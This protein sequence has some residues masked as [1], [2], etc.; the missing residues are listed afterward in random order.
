[1]CVRAVVGRPVV[2][3]Q[4]V[5]SVE[6]VVRWREQELRRELALLAAKALALLGAF[7]LPVLSSKRRHRHR[8]PAAAAAE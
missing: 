6:S 3:A 8:S 1:M 5:K 7:V 4:L 2:V